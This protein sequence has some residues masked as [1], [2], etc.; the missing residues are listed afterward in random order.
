MHYIYFFLIISNHAFNI[1]F[2]SQNLMKHADKI[3]VLFFTSFSSV[4]MTTYDYL[5]LRKKEIWFRLNSAIY[6]W[7]LIKKKQFLHISNKC[8]E[9]NWNGNKHEIILNKQT[10]KKKRP[11]K[12]ENP[13][14]LKPSQLW[15]LLTYGHKTGTDVCR[16]LFSAIDTKLAFQSFQLITSD[17]I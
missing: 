17:K 12:K 3:F 2:S 5:T 11:H 9:F 4:W 6:S 13:Y 8:V 15:N 7:S 1:R 10:N 14:Y 16:I